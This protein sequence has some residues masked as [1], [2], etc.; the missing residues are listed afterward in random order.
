MREYS[1]EDRDSRLASEMLQRN[2]EIARGIEGR[3]LT[4]QK[5]YCDLST[6]QNANNAMK[7]GVPFRSLFVRTATDSS[8]VVYFSPNENS[9]GNIAE[10]MPLYKND[11]FNFG[12]TISG[13]YLWWTAQAGK[14]IEIYLAT[15]GEMKPGSQV[16]QIAGGLSVSDGSS[17]ISNLLTGGVATIAI[18]TGTAQ[19]ILDS[20]TD[21]KAAEL[22]FDA[23]V[24][25]GDS[26]S[27]AVGARGRLVQAG[28]YIYR[29]TAALYATAVSGTANVY[30]NIHK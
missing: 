1:A 18:V 19:K 5:V 9:I 12:K 13:G 7:I 29:N 14:I 25:V 23:D 3:V 22:Y 21:R 10:A 8:A 6:A 30:G 11:S 4:F 17:L 26:T 20:D 15:D 2:A 28:E 27:V 24:W 16:S